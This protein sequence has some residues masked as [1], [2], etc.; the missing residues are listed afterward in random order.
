MKFMKKLGAVMLSVAM[1]AIS[2]V[3]PTANVS[4]VDNGGIV[5]TDDYTI[6][7]DLSI[8]NVGGSSVLNYSA[9]DFAKMKADG[10]DF[11]ILRI[12]FE[13]SS[14]RVDTLD[15]AFKEYY[16]RAREAGMKLG[17]YFYA[18]G[19]SYEQAKQDAEWVINVIEENDMYFEYPICYDVEDGAHYALNATQ[20]TNTCYGWAETL[21]MHGYYPAIYVNR[22]LYKKISDDFKAEYDIWYRYIAS[23]DA[24]ATQYD[25]ATLNISDQCS[26]W[27]YTMYQEFDGCSVQYTQN[28][29]DGNVSYKD[30]TAII[31]KNGYNNYGAKTNRNL[32]SN[33]SYTI[34]ADCDPEYNANL[35]DGVA[36]TVSPEIDKS[37]WA[38]VGQGPEGDPETCER[39]NGTITVDL[40][41]VYDIT[42]IATHVFKDE[43][44][45]CINSIAINFSTDGVN[46]QEICGLELD[47]E[48]TAPYW[49]TGDIA[50]IKSDCAL[51][52]IDLNTEARY[53][54][55]S[56]SSRESAAECISLI[57]E[58][59]IYGD[60]AGE[61]SNIAIDKKLE[62]PE[63]VRGYTA[64]LNDGKI[65]TNFVVG[66][67]D[68]Y[69]LFFN[70][71]AKDQNCPTAVGT[72]VID[73]QQPCALDEIKLHYGSGSG[74]SALE[75]VK[76]FF[77]N[78][79]ENYSDVI[80]L[81]KLSS[82]AIG[83]FAADV[84]GIVA[85]YVKVEVVM[86][87]NGYWGMFDEIEVYGVEPT[88]THLRG[89]LTND[90]VIDM[91]DYG[92]LK[93][94]CFG[95]ASFDSEIAMKAADVNADDVVDMKDYGLLKRFC[96]GTANIDNPYVY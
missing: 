5:K 66:T 36:S 70:S 21:E 84:T 37:A 12:G 93:R 63:A 56:F 91:K 23:A 83:W 11:A 31:E 7:V 27:Q 79:G 72:V 34:D 26:L 32:A 71:A 14:T 25:P 67:P 81:D 35:T 77:S 43:N 50:Q 64:K 74:V 85:R 82:D 45:N 28:Q 3:V 17:V 89:E 18:L 53:V 20:L 52:G 59:E 68:W 61:I 86:N 30:Y 33:K 47:Y 2:S 90:G 9:V 42:S 49:A 62:A 95:T 1:L 38:C 29:L 4:A 78:D 69:G 92:L 15:L 88:N 24:N 75:G 57:N 54:R 87:A 8:W 39:C 46:F 58:I 51:D 19:T 73:L 80:V 76:V 10:C 65:A 40:G 96:F 6:G 60:L 44:P 94:F 48:T 55:F 13:G 16:K 41:A 22:E